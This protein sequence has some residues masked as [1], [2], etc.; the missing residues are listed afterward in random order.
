MRPNQ[1]KK[2]P[3]LQLGIMKRKGIYEQP[4]NQGDQ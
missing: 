2:N 1:G 4:T 3:Q